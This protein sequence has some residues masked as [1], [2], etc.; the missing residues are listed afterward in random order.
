M[1]G[2]LYNGKVKSLNRLNGLFEYNFAF[3]G[4]GSR[5]TLQININVFKTGLITFTR[6]ILEIYL[7]YLNKLYS[8]LDKL[9]KQ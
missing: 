8:C 4:E 2:H 3:V 9:Y 1:E 5:P 7:Q 6:L